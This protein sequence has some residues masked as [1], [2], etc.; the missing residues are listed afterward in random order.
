M[1]R[2][3]ESKFSVYQVTLS[4]PDGTPYTIMSSKPLLH[5]DNGHPLKITDQVELTKKPVKK[6][7]SN[8]I[9]FLARFVVLCEG[10]FDRIKFSQ[11]NKTITAYPA[12]INIFQF[13]FGKEFELFS[14]TQ[15]ISDS[16]SQLAHLSAC[17]AR[18][19]LSSAIDEVVRAAL[20][21]DEDLAR[22]LI[23]ANPNYL[24][25]RSNA[26]DFSGRIY[27]DI[28]PFQAAL[29]AG[30]VQMC[31]MMKHH[32]ASIPNGEAEMQKQL[33]QV[34]ANNQCIDSHADLTSIFNSHLEKQKQSTQINFK[35]MLDAVITAIKNA[36]FEDLIG[37][38]YSQHNGPISVEE[39]IKIYIIYC[40]E[41]NFENTSDFFSDISMR[42]LE[43]KTEI[44]LR[45]CIEKYKHSAL[46]NTLLHFKTAFKQL[47]ND[48][49]VFNPQHL[50]YALKAIVN[51]IRDSIS[52][53]KKNIIWRDVVGFIQRF[54]P[55]C[56][57]QAY[58]QGMCHIF[59]KD[60]PLQRSFYTLP[61][62]DHSKLGFDFAIHAG[63]FYDYSSHY[64]CTNSIILADYDFL[65]FDSQ[66]TY[67][68]R[69]ISHQHEKLSEFTRSI[70][71][72]SCVLQ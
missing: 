20:C 36:S 48:E 13:L 1:S 64:K 31:E 39:A 5:D 2:A 4:K 28:T 41:K 45:A 37:K 18:P 12:W 15:N 29:F 70:R 42:D 59:V 27:T 17:I 65:C 71:S 53:D 57:I 33:R 43:L 9:L 14:F 34:F 35:P 46:N 58:T 6:Y 8:A 52:T 44:K 21:G 69:F 55:A 30:D 32:F 7:D 63:N 26:M 56:Y 19:A 51:L 23:A 38:L 24:F 50:L 47:S 62:L 72:S 60:M 40:H 22:R 10:N 68:A 66:E 61:F 11:S 3:A 16:A 25:Q 67:I 49:K 54:L